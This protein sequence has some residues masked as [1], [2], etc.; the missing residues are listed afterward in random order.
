[1]LGLLPSSLLLYCSVSFRNVLHFIA[2]CFFSP[3]NRTKKKYAGN[4]I[5][6]Y[7]SVCERESHGMWLERQRLCDSQRETHWRCSNMFLLLP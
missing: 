5:S 7:T 4:V 2:A 3:K 6:V 1:M